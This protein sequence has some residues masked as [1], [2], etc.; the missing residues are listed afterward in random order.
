MRNPTASACLTVYVPQGCG[1]EITVLGIDVSKGTLDSSLVGQNQQRLWSQ[2]VKNTPDGIEQLLART[3]P[4][5]AWVV[6][7]TGRYSALVVKQATEAGR[8]VLLAPNRAAHLYLRSLNTRAKTDKIDGFGLAMFG[9]S[10]PLRPFPIKSVSLENLDQLLSARKG[11][12]NSLQRARLQQSELEAVS[13]VFDPVI[14]ALVSQ[15]QVLDKRI[16]ELTQSDPAFALVKTLQQVPGVGPV[17]SA[18]VAS[19]LL[20]K[21]FAHP[22]A[23]VSYV[24]LD[25]AVRQSGKSEG[26]V[27]LTKQGDAELRRLLYMAAMANLRAKESVFKSQYER[28]RASGRNSTAALNI[29]A[30]KIAHVCWALYRHGGSFDPCKV[31]APPSN[32]ADT[33]LDAKHA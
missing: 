27:K 28:L 10:R 3:D 24:G 8:T 16:K 22:D 7:P 18:A 12:A 30:R 1:G 32:K 15:I 20:G 6:E 31:Y 19:R 4:A 2:K 21:Q 9:L 5:I 14:E 26:R 11:L 17:A 25:V 13:D 33:E 29:V 23:F